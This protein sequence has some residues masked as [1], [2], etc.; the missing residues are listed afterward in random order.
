MAALIDAEVAVGNFCRSRA[1]TAA[2]CG[3]AAEVPQK[4]NGGL[5]PP[6]NVLTLQSLATRSGLL[7]ILGDGNGAAGVIPLTGP[8]SVVTGP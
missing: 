2:A 4:G 3:A 6:K 7:T 5:A 8:N 1:A